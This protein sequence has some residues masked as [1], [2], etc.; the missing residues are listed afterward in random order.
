MFG[1]TVSQQ[2][3]VRSTGELGLVVKILPCRYGCWYHV[4]TQSGD[5]RKCRERDLGWFS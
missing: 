5:L 3:V 1:I 4:L 2:V